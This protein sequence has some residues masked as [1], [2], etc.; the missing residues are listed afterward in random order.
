MDLSAYI[1]YIL[2]GVLSGLLS[3]MLGVGGGLVTVPLLLIVFRT[4][5]LPHLFL[6]QLA[7]ATS[8]AAMIITLFASSMAH[9]LM[10]SVEWALVKILFPGLAAGAILGAM[11]SHLISSA[12]LEIVFGLFAIVAGVY[13]Y[14]NRPKWQAEIRKVASWQWLLFG[15]GIGAAASLLGVGGT[16]FTAPLLL[17]YHYP[18]KK[19]VGTAAASGMIVAFFA[20]CA[21]LYLGRGYTEL[22]GT[23]GYIFLPAFFCISFAAMFAAPKGVEWAQKLPQETLRKFFALFL[24]VAGLLM[25]L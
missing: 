21:Y 14:K 25:V 17:A 13:F 7:V 5:E 12:L 6:M 22:H 19:A 11:V 10:G 1:A 24:V 2:I 16:L 8:L 23:V 18:E 4:A 15:L 3:G 9:H 20:T